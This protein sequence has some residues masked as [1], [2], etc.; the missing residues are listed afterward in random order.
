ME[1]DECG[2]DIYDVKVRVGENGA[3]DPEI[4]CVKCGAPPPPQIASKI[5]DEVRMSI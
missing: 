1:C 5:L 2:W 3:G 4:E